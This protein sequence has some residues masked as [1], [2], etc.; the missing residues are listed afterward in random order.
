MTRVE[1]AGLLVEAAEP[2]AVAEFWSRAL[3]GAT[4][5]LPDG[6]VQVMGPHPELTIYPQARPK[7]V[8][9]RVH[10]DVYARSVDPLLALGGRVLDEYL[11]TRVT[12]A[13]VEGNE[14][15]AFLDPEFSSAPRVRDA[16]ARLF[17]VCTDSDRPEELAAW[18]AVLT[19]ADVRNGGDGTP[20]WLYDAAGWRELIWKFVRVGDEPLGRRANNSDEPLGRRANNSDEPLGRRA[21]NSDERV[22]PN[23]WRWTVHAGTADLVTAGASV[24]QP[25]VLLDPQLNEFSVSERLG[26]SAG[27]P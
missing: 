1:M 16:P 24:A 23:R 27:V 12:L 4:T 13:D 3:G 11:P 8:K 2:A 7:M 15:C 25:G 17:A 9:N 5:T 22:V 14:F 10:F 20:R 18:W 21:N 19:G 26:K 6:S